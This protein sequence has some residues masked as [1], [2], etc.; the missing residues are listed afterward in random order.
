MIM[1][2]N[3]IIWKGEL[4]G[5]SLRDNWFLKATIK[6]DSFC[7]FPQTLMCLR[8]EWMCST[9]AMNPLDTQY[10]VIYSRNLFQVLVQHPF[11]FYY[12]TIY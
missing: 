6:K 7:G 2:L 3:K 1:T 8:Q 9:M 11:D 12:W 5:N 4:T 10:K